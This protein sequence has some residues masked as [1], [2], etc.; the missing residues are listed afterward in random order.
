MEGEF[1]GFTVDGGPI[2]RF[3]QTTPRCL[4]DNSDIL[5]YCDGNRPIVAFRKDS[6]QF[7]TSAQHVEEVKRSSPL[8]KEVPIDTV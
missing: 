6:I 3:T 4:D 8:A 1:I 5:G 7:L 2:I